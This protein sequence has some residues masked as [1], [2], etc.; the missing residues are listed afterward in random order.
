M[1]HLIF[2]VFG[3]L[4]VVSLFGPFL[5]LIEVLWV[6]F[7]HFLQ[8]L[9]PEFVKGETEMKLSLFHTVFN[10][11]NT[12]LLVWFVKLIASIVIKVIPSKGD[13]DEEFHLEYIS[14]GI[15]LTP[16]ISILEAKKEITK[17]GRLA[18]KMNG[19][20]TKMLTEQ[21]NRSFKQILEK[22]KSYE[23]ITDRIEAEITAYVAKV[24]EGEM[25]KDSSEQMRGMLSIAGDLERVGDV[26]YQMSMALERKRDEKIWFT[27]EQR[28]NLLEMYAMVEKCFINMNDNLVKEHKHVTIDKALELERALN[29]LRKKIRKEHFSN[30]ENGEYNFKSAIIYSDMFNS[31]EKV[32]DHIINV[33][34]AI[35]GDVPDADEL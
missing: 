2:N 9:N 10:I 34:E 21:D 1:A 27:P 28:T 11:F 4:W 23:D 24:S 16:E 15:M 29:K 12:L 14:G 18:F 25:S 20:L 3:V 6:P 13:A 32:G 22:V 31:L 17:F 26:Y 19:L 7:H 30:V 33:T 5:Q 8:S 35:I